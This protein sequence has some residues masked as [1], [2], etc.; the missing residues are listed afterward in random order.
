MVCSRCTFCLR[1][2]GYWLGPI[3]RGSVAS[4]SALSLP[5]G[6]F[7][8]LRLLGGGPCFKTNS[9]EVVANPTL[10][11]RFA[12]GKA[13]FPGV[14]SPPIPHPKQVPG[15]RSNFI[16]L[17]LIHSFCGVCNEFVRFLSRLKGLG[18]GYDVLHAL[19][20]SIRL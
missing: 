13:C 10:C 12:I 17:W 14:G 19:E 6:S 4:A 3:T 9:G 20:R 5:L 15:S 8:R 1:G 16:C 7:P 2:G 18:F 11:A